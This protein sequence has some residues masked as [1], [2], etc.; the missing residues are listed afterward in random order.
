[1]PCLQSLEAS[2]RIPFSN[3]IKYIIAFEKRRG[4]DVGWS[5]YL[6]AKAFIEKLRLL[7]QHLTT[8]T[9]DD[10]LPHKRDVMF[11]GHL[12]QPCG[13]SEH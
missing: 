2:K 12:G 9:N 3:T 6:C 7:M 5:G 11:V 13:A 8:A 4:G 1:M 10:P